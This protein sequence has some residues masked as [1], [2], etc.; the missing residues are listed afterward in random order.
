VNRLGS[1]LRQAEFHILVILGGV[2]CL[3]WPLMSVFE[4]SHPAIMLAYLFL[5]WTIL[6]VLLGLISRS[7]RA[8]ED[9]SMGDK[10]RGN[11]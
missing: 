4:Q 10:A 11:G 5:I 2:V 6:I 8:K 9:G 3:G 1:I 7:I